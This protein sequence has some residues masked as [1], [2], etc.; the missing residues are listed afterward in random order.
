MKKFL[1]FHTVV[2]LCLV[3]A[4]A[5]PPAFADRGRHDVRPH[6][7]G[8]VHHYRDGRWYRDSF[9]WFDTAVTF[10][11]IGALVD[12]LPPRHTTVVYSGVP[13]YYADG[14][15][16]RVYDQGGYVVVQPPI[17][18][19]TIITQPVI[20]QPL[21]MAQQVPTV[22]VGPAP[23]AAAVAQTTGAA[24]QT[25]S[26]SAVSAAQT[27][28]SADAVT[29]NIPNSKGG[30]TPVVL[31]KAGTGYIGP[32]GEYYAENPTVA[33]LKTLYSGW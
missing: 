4:L 33:Q 18:A 22:S 1:R 32:Q 21:V 26:S 17:V 2:V 7:R 15:Y 16:Y 20:T 24:T 3:L 14:Y 30:Y 25:V 11:A 23:T 12:R 19:Q 31:T 28:P 9:L 6:K 10:L 13:Y 27:A 29:I 8:P 5:C